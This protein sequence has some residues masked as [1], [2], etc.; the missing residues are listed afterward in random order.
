MSLFSCNLSRK[1]TVAKLLQQP[2]KK[3]VLEL[4]FEKLGENHAKK[5]HI[6]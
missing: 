1:R 5:I 2:L 3:H 6:D 4:S